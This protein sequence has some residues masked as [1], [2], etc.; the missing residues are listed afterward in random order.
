MAANYPRVDGEKLLQLREPMSRKM[1]IQKAKMFLGENAEPMREKTI[2]RWEKGGGANP[3]LLEAV[4]RVFGIALKDL[5]IPTEPTTTFITDI[6]DQRELRLLRKSFEC[7]EI[8]FPNEEERDR[9]ENIEQWIRESYAGEVTEDP[10]REIYGV[11]HI[12]ERVFGMAYLSV[13]LKYPWAFGSYF[14]VLKGWRKGGRAQSFYKNIIK[15]ILSINPTVKGIIF[16]I[17]PIDFTYLD[18]I[19]SNL[20]YVHLDDSV[21]NNRIITNLRSIN[22]LLIFQTYSAK[23]VLRK[24]GSPLPY[25][26]PALFEPLDES[27]EKEMILMVNPFKDVIFESKELADI[28]D[29]I[30]DVLY[31]DSFDAE[32]GQVHLGGYRR[33]ISKVKARVKSALKRGCKI[34]QFEISDKILKLRNIA[35][36]RG[37][38]EEIDP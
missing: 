16:E 17:D 12:G 22:R 27:N 28:V 14:G 1:L 20:D 23:P 38:E 32:I 6:D 19:L 18:E 8:L 31:T 9:K 11:L 3:E 15:K 5:I 30:Y 34:K 37:Y 4:A 25:W 2:A 33:Y 29:F 24:N 7:Y 26:Q 35:R 36:E 10:W 13:H 21:L